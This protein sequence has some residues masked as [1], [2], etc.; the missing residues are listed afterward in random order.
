VAVATAVAAGVVLLRLGSRSLWFDEGVT[1]GLAREPFDRFVERVSDHEVNQS[2]FYALFDLWH[3][4]GEGVATMRL[5]PAAFFVATVPLVF[6]VGRRLLDARVGALAAL[7]VALHPLAV[8]WGQQ[9]RAYTMVMFLVTLAT[10]LLLRAVEDPTPLRVLA[11]A[12]VGAVAV[13]AHFFAALVLL[14]HA[15]SLVVR[16]PFPRR[17]AAGSAVLLA[18]LCAPATMFVLGRQGDPLDW[19]VAPG[20]SGLLTRLGAVAGGTRIQLAAYGFAGFV[21][22]AALWGVVRRAPRS[23]EAWR[24]AL[25]VLWLVVPPVVVLVSTYTVKPLLVPSYLLVIVPAMAIVAA[26][27]VVRFADRRVAGVAAAVLLAASLLGLVRY[28]RQEG[29]EAWREAMASVLD[30]AGPEDGIVAVPTHARPLVRY[31]VRHSDGPQ[32][33]TLVPSAEDGPGPA[34]VWELQ[35]DAPGPQDVLPDWDPLQTY[36]RWLDDHYRLDDERSF[37]RVVVRRW[38]RR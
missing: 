13:F 11:Y 3:H 29:Q 36:D 1:L 31:Y 5:L 28:H 21:G 32:L 18:A 34:V 38:E 27:G 4:V 24:A 17:V 20:L 6:V 26:A 25:P 8:G 22:V 15:L 16:Q 33:D 37:E 7:L 10:Y 12:L 19:V 9:L 2:A 35:R 23:D 14:G 30:D